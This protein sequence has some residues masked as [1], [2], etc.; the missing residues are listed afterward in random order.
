MH[1]SC[2][3]VPQPRLYAA[4][5]WPTEAAELCL[6]GLEGRS[7]SAVLVSFISTKKRRDGEIGTEQP[8]S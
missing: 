7:L 8:Q 5:D 1:A 2:P 6:N 3:G 4:T